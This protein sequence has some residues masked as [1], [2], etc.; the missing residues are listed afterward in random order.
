MKLLII[1]LLPLIY[2]CEKEYKVH[3]K[4]GILFI[5][6]FQSEITKVKEVDWKV[7][8]QRE[9]VIS[10]GLR[11]HIS[12]PRIDQKGSEL[13]KSKYGVDSYIFRF[14]KVTKGRPQ[15]IGQFFF[16]FENMTR[17]T[18][19]LSISLFYQAASISKEFRN[20]HCPAFKHRYKVDSF[21]IENRSNTDKTALYARMSGNVR[22]QVGQIRFS[23]TVL[24]GGLNLKGK[25]F[26]DMALYS[27]TKKQRYS[28]W[29]KVGKVLNVKR[30][31]SV[32]V[33]SCL[34]VKEEVR[35]LPESRIPTIR[36]LEIK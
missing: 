31:V 34:G 18:K 10:K 17:N 8:R 33:P 9:E 36:D 16:R 28:S 14:S 30:E 12:M 22:G 35:P 4:N 13:L 26:V 24:P 19:D 3:Q 27:S 7:G 23:P 32:N 2:S 21:D 6:D 11:V 5:K 20:H 29:L 1:L 25:Y 15:A